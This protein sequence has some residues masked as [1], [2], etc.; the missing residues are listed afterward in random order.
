MNCDMPV[1]RMIAH[2]KIKA[3]QGR[4]AIMRGPL[5]YCFEGLDSP[6]AATKGASQL[7]LVAD[8]QFEIKSK[9]IIPGMTVDA[10]VAKDHLGRSI[11][12][13]PYFARA[14][15]KETSMSVWLRQIGLKGESDAVSWKGKLYRSLDPKKLA[16]TAKTPTE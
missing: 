2:P 6:K 12:A 15:R 16:K 5:V 4:V 7:I 1:V 10:I 9:E 8:Q 13:I 3:D 11:T 14:Y